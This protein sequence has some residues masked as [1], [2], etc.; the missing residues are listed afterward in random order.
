MV[1]VRLVPMLVPMMIGMPCFT[2]S[3][4]EATRVTTREVVA[5]EDCKSR[6][7]L[8]SKGVVRKMNLEEG[9]GENAKGETNHWTVVQ[10]AR[11]EKGVVRHLE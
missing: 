10:L 4:L 3:A 7:N 1:E 11:V 2:V 6:L 9:G 8:I 5:D